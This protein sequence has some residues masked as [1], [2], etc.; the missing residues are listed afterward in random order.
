MGARNFKTQVYCPWKVAY[1]PYV[2][3]SLD[4]EE[5]FW[6]YFSLAY[7]GIYYFL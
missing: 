1:I 2:S 3:V 7:N 4:T 5:Y 6:F